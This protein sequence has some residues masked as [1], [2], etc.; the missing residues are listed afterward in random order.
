MKKLNLTLTRHWF[1]KILA[2]E[3]KSEYREVKEHWNRRFSKGV[4]GYSS[5]VFINGYNSDSPGME[6]AIIDMEIVDGSLHQPE[7][8]EPLENNNFYYKI[9][10]GELISSSNTDGAQL[11]L[12]P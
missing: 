6:L 10:L 7:N 9:N 8:G 12:C 1:N 4:G 2:G 5:V 3:K 11:G